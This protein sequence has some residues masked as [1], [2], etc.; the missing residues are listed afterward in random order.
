M[1]A[2]KVQEVPGTA[3]VFY[4]SSYG[5]AEWRYFCDPAEADTIVDA[6]NCSLLNEQDV[7]RGCHRA[8]AEQEGRTLFEKARDVLGK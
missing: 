5:A 4:E 7:A 6:L 8:R 3:E 1:Q 2:R